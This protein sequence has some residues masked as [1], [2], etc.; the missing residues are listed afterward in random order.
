[1]LQNNPTSNAGRAAER[2][3]KNHPIQGSA[4]EIIKI[5]M[6][7][8]D[9]WLDKQGKKTRMVLQVHDE[10]VFE[11]PEPELDEVLEPL[12]E[13]MESAMTLSVPLKVDAKVGNN[14]AEMEEVKE[15]KLNSKIDQAQK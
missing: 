3:A 11:V 13:M 1:M 15:N 12:V 6:V 7:R 8:I 5:A 10:L 14:W 9:E 2:A 4:A